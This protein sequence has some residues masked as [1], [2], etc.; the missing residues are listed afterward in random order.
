MAAWF[1]PEV[2][3]NVF[4]RWTFLAACRQSI[5]RRVPAVHERIRCYATLVASLRHRWVFV[6]LLLE[7]LMAIDERVYDVAKATTR[8]RASLSARRAR[9]PSA[10]RADRAPPSPNGDSAARSRR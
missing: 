2:R 4:Q 1:S 9:A 7:P 5:R 10:W 3:R 6:F 8:A